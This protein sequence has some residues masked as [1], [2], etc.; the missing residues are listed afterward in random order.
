MKYAYYK[1]IIQVKGVFELVIFKYLSRCT[2]QI[3]NLKRKERLKM[4]YILI[5][6]K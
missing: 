2:T 3:N 1:Y 6:K 5:K 4:K